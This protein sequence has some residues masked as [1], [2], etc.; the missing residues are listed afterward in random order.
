MKKIQ[1]EP[2]VEPEGAETSTGNEAALPFQGL[3]PAPTIQ[4]EI[5]ALTN[6]LKNINSMV[7]AI[8]DIEAGLATLGAEL[9][10]VRDLEEAL[11][12]KRPAGDI[13]AEIASRSADL[14]AA[15]LARSASPQVE[16]KLQQLGKELEEILS[17]R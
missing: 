11:A 16:A 15:I 5:T 8:A 14:R 10:E 3:S 6:E 12:K 9:A 1:E 4:A 13:E 2:G 7:D 17:E